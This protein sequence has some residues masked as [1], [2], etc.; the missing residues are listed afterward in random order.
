MKFEYSPCIDGT[1]LRAFQ[2]HFY[3]PRSWKKTWEEFYVFI[4]KI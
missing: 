4:W 3:Q 2:Y 1:A